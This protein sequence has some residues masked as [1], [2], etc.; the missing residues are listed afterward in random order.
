[1]CGITGILHYSNRPVDRDVLSLMTD[2]LVHRG[3]DAQ[4]LYV[5]KNIGLGHRRLSIID[6]Q[7]GDQPLASDDASTVIVFN[8]EIYNYLE[9]RDELESTGVRFRTASDTEVILRAYEKWGIAC[10]ERFNGMWAFAIWDAGRKELFL[11]RDR[12][13]EKPLYYCEYDNSFL[14]G[15]EAKSLLRYGV[16]AEPDMEMLELY[17]TLGYVPAPHSFYR[18]LKKLMPGHCLLVSGGK[19]TE[20]T[21]W[22]FPQASES[23]M[24]TDVSL[25]E[26]EFEEL[27]HDSVRIRMRSDVPFG[28]F[29][30][31]GL[32]SSCIV[33][34]MSEAGA[35]SVE[36]FTIGYEEESYDERPLAR[37]VA[38]RFNTNHHEFVVEKAV[39]GDALA[40]TLHH[41]DEPFGDSSAIPTGIVSREAGGFVKMVLTGDGGDEVLSGYTSYQGEK[42]SAAYR[43]IP[44]AFQGVMPA[45]AG[46][47]GAFTKGSLRY[48]LN[49]VKSVTASAALPFERRLINKLSWAPPDVVKS[50]LDDS[51][52]VYPVEDYIDGV[53]GQC[54]FSDPFYRLMYFHF[55]VT[56]PEGMLTKVDRM[57]MAYSLETRLPFLDHRLVEL[58]AGVDRNVKMRGYERKSVLRGTVGKRLPGEIL[59]APKKGFAI[60]LREWFKGDSFN[61]R[62]SGIDAGR[63]GI[64]A[65]VADRII[66]DNRAGRNDYGTFIWMLVLLDQWRMGQA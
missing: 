42:F 34:L 28:A 3:P 41:Y 38:S 47:L 8:G 62:L 11:S 20:R 17:L 32:D 33:A 66:Q 45:V 19:V 63:A 52:H 1:M 39:F 43:K 58:M 65:R 5:D 35:H 22:E 15:S 46:L 30:S 14:F 7:T 44:G 51:R 18:R 57:S 2:T 25:I 36:T 48:R 16:P 4:G 61:D 50:L 40:R 31:G 59:K 54:S 12:I 64:N 24:R 10:Q 37:R 9:I 13:G 26:S 29:L 21:Y 53:L 60:P 49:R 6:L 55:A 27:L 23:D 56:L